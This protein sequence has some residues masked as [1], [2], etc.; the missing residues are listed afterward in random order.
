MLMADSSIRGLAPFHKA[1]HRR[2]LLFA[3]GTN[4]CLASVAGTGLASVAGTGLA[5]GTGT[6][7][8]IAFSSGTY[9]AG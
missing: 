6:R 1:S 8:R 3:L 9:P 5:L 4:T 7:L 2:S